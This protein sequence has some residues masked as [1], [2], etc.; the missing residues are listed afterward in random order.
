MSFDVV[1]S[2][3]TVLDEMDKGKKGRKEKNNTGILHEITR[4]YT[5]I[6]WIAIQ[7]N[8]RDDTGILFQAYSQGTKLQLHQS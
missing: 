8:P 2:W 3:K 5:R 4:I 7:T 1:N 6:F